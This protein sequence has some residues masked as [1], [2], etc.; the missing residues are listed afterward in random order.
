METD[1]ASRFAILTPARIAYIVS[2][3]FVPQGAAQIIPLSQLPAQMLV[4]NGTQAEPA[5]NPS[6]T[7][8]ASF[9]QSAQSR[10]WTFAQYLLPLVVSWQ[11]HNIELLQ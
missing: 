3:G 6:A 10:A 8:S 11:A 4:E 9:R 5:G 7:Q 1:L 2:G